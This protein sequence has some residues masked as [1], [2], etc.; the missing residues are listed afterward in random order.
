MNVASIAV[1]CGSEK[2]LQDT[3]ES[4]G[5]TLKL[6][7]H[8]EGF[9]E[10]LKTGHPPTYSHSLRVATTALQIGRLYGVD[11][12]TLFLASLLHDFGKLGI[13]QELLDKAEWDEKDQ[14]AMEPHVIIGYN[15]VLDHFGLEFERIAQI[16]VR[17]HRFQPHAY[18]KVLP[19][20]CRP[21]TSEEI[22]QVDFHARILALADGYDAAVYR[23]CLSKGI[24]K[25]LIDRDDGNPPIIKRSYRNR[26]LVAP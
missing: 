5:V 8:L 17:H 21:Y 18:P 9:L 23:R 4:L 12:M 13:C 15:C 25:Y 16:M 14:I 3:L 19:K 7:F 6:R 2:S 26:I 10:P 22:E 1:D 20:P 24:K 11:G